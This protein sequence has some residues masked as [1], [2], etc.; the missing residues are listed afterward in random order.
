MN[1]DEDMELDCILAGVDFTEGGEVDD[2]PGLSLELVG[3]VVTPTVDA[4]SAQGMASRE[5]REA[6]TQTG[7]GSCQGPSLSF[8]LGRSCKASLFTTYNETNRYH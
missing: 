7:E 2:E 1:L 5:G 6:V 4:G 8:S 3:V